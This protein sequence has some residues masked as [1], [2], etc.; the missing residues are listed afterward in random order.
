MKSKVAVFFALCVISSTVKSYKILG[1]LQ[2]ASKSHYIIGHAIM[3]ALAEEGNDVTVLTPFKEKYPIKN[4]EEVYLE[5]SV[6]DGLKGT[7][8]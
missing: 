4:Y 8:L 7:I 1:V 2:S 3:K 6:S 5:R